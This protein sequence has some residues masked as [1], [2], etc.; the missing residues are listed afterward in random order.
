MSFSDQT[1]HQT[2]AGRRATLAGG[3]RSATAPVAHE[4]TAE[5]VE[6]A[7]LRHHPRN[8]RRGAVEE[9]K[10]SLE[11]HGQYRPIV[12]NA[13]TREVLAGNHTLR[14]ARE[15]GWDEI[16][17]TWLSVDDEQALRILLVDNATN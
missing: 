4:L 7:T 6:I 3:A 11:Q 8:P 1:E 5:R 13:R 16:W 17:V 2:T 10:R 15:L 9:I 12:A 14:A